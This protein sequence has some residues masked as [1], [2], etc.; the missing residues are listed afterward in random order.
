MQSVAQGWVVVGLTDSAATVAMVMFVSSIPM[1]G[2]SLHGGLVADRFSRRK[3]LIATQILLGVTA[4]GYGLLVSTG[5]LTLVWVYV[6]SLALGAIIAFD[7]P[8][9]GA[10]VP[11]LV[12]KEDVPRAVALNM[13]AFHASRLVGPFLAAILIA[14][15]GTAWAFYVNALSYLAVLWSL[16]VIRPHPTEAV[17]GATG[18]A[19][20]LEGVRYIRQDRLI[21]AVIAYAGI[22]TAFVFPFIIVFLPLVVKTVLGGDAKTLGTMISAAGLGALLGALALLRIPARRRGPTLVLSAALAGVVLFALGLARSPWQA[23]SLMPLL[24]GCMSVSVGLGMTIVQSTVPSKLRGRVLA[25]HNLMWTGL[26]PVSALLFG[27]L[28]DAIS[29]GRTMD[30]MAGLYLALAVVVLVRAE[31]WRTASADPTAGSAASP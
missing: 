29:L 7:L 5:A 25:I 22:A 27:K 1:V 19:A 21:R 14:A 10:L 6:L 17:V 11:D 20:L 15:L 31:I 12:P 16:A 26:M 9:S 24:T 30:L 23:V 18:L 13:A 8:A 3:V 28:A 4:A 2:L